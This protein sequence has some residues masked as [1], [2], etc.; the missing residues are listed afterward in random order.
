[1][2]T[3]VQE[4]GKKEKS[5]FQRL[6]KQSVRN[7]ENI[8]LA[9]EGGV[10]AAQGTFAESQAHE[11]QHTLQGYV[12]Q[13][14]IASQAQSFL[15]GHSPAA[16]HPGRA[17]PHYGPT[18]GI[19]PPA[20][21]APPLTAGGASFHYGNEKPTS[22]NV[23]FPTS[24]THATPVGSSFASS[25][26]HGSAHPSF[27][28]SAAP[29][30]PN[31]PGYAPSYISPAQPSNSSFASGHTHPRDPSSGMGHAPSF[32]GA[33]APSFPA[34]PGGPNAGGGGGGYAA[35]PGPPPP[36]GP[37][38]GFPGAGGYTSQGFGFPD[39]DAS[40]SVKFPGAPGGW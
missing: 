24:P 32:P 39:E 14:P 23:G 31:H 4:L 35:P 20:S 2:R 40:P 22:H 1:M 17:G 9:G 21:L 27:P 25:A 34:F 12:N 11:F 18:G 38:T 28:G 29:A 7:H 15:G 5:I 16:A 8:R 3:W 13:T 19:N 36:Q 26:P 30:A 37:A 6:N 33:Q 10:S